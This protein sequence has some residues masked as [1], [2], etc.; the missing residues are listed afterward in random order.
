MLDHYE[1]NE[2]KIMVQD[3]C[4]ILETRYD[5][6]RSLKMWESCKMIN[7]NI[8]KYEHIL[9]KLKSIQSKGA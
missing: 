8:M 9:K 4:K 2:L 3:K 7:E 1:I 5:K 6:N